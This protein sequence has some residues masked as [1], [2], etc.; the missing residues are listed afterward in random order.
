MNAELRGG[1]NPEV[2]N[3]SE[4]S[5]LLGKPHNVIL[6]NDDVN[7]FDSVVA[8][9]TKATK[10]SMD[11]AMSIALEAH[12]KGKSVAFSGYLERCEVVEQVLSGPPLRLG[13]SIESI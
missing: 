8:Q 9:I 5:N 3:L 11:K 10:C 1:A 6:F 4:V 13:T 7:P 12:T 2:S